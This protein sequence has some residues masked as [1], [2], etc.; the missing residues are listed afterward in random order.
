MKNEK[1]F[2]AIITKKYLLHHIVNDYCNNYY[3]LIVGK[4]KKNKTNLIKRFKF[5]LFFDCYDLEDFKYS[6]M[7]E[8]LEEVKNKELDEEEYEQLKRKN[9]I[10]KKDKTDFINETS[11]EKLEMINS[12]ED[13]KEFID[14]CKKTLIEYNK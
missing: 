14:F 4:I 13:C 11:Y 7:I 2:E 1:D 9:P 8:E 10:T 3:Y 6:S 12:F 5:I